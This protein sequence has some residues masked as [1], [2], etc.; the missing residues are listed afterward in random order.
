[1]TLETWTLPTFAGRP[2]AWVRGR[3]RASEGWFIGLAILIGAAAGLMTVIQGRVAHAIQSRIFGAG[4]EATL[5]AVA[6]LAPM[7]VLW[8]PVGGGL[9]GIF[10]FALGRRE[11][12]PLID[13]VEG[14]AL[15][16]GRISLR[17]SLVICLQTLVSNGFG[18]SVG[19][20]AAYAQAG[21][22]I[23]SLLGRRLRLRRHDLRTLVGAGAGAAI[24]AA[25]GAPLTGAFYAFE[26]VIGSYAPSMIAPVAAAALAAVL[27]ARALGAVSYSI[28]VTVLQSPGA[29]DY[30]LYAGLGAICAAFGVIL[31]ILVARSEALI[32]RV[33]LP[34][35]LRPAIGGLALAALALASPQTLSSGHG[36]LHIDLATKLPLAFLASVLVLKALASVI[37]LGSG[38]RGGLFFASLFLGSLLG[39]IYARLLAL[40]DLPVAL[41]PEN[42]ALVGMGAL[43]T[44]IVGGPLTMSFLV[45]ETTRDFGVAAATL[46]ASLVA[47]SVV[48][49][50]F[51]YSFSTWRL[52]L[53]GETI[54]SARDVGWVRSLTAGRMM[55]ADVP[56]IA[57]SSTLADFRRRFPLGSTTRVILLDDADRYAGIV[58][59]AT[60]Y[61]EGRDDD[62]LMAQLAES[63]D[64]K[65]SPDMNI[66][67][68]MKAF[69]A[70]ETDEL[71][72]VDESGTVLGLLAELYVSRRYAKEL[73][74]VQQGLFG[75]T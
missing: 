30:A 13:V 5:S 20:E 63:R 28:H 7:S 56:T 62:E 15:Y 16:G 73:E 19:L 21:G 66:A 46:A 29:I 72:V 23:A 64:V 52:H 37:S 14:N 39:Q 57:Q 2:L 11:T 27:S 58:Q 4:A 70:T 31:M 24:G 8:L 53:R 25:F 32:R 45:L 9:L 35:P 71:A 10:G 26:V 41:Q 44:A 40:T 65:L 74:Q 47:S 55:R 42:A 22:G 43:A 38:F 6:A 60:A 50:R 49:E 54:R 75:E 17:G 12:P 1:V 34:A 68:V 51:G 33:P 18:A 59:T 61:V 67:E 3:F 69:D 48:R 36:A